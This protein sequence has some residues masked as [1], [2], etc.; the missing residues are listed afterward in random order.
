MSLI[1]KMLADLEARA[2]QT[3][4]MEDAPGPVHEGLRAA[5]P[6]GRARP[7]WRSGLWAG[8]LAVVLS[9]AVASVLLRGMPDRKDAAVASRTAVATTAAATVTGQPAVA[10]VSPQHHRPAGVD[11]APAGRSPTPASS[12][13]AAAARSSSAAPVVTP[14]PVVAVLPDVS[15]AS[16]PRH[17][18]AE[19][20]GRHAGRALSAA[21][22]TPAEDR[23]QPVRQ[24]LSA[25][26]A[27]R[28]MPAP[29]PLPR[30]AARSPAPDAR[31]AVS[32]AEPLAI[33]RSDGNDAAAV[34]RN[35]FSRALE[36]IQQARLSEAEEALRSALQYDPA[37][38]KARVTLAKVLIKQGRW[39]EAR[40]LL[41]DG[42]VDDA[43]NIELV[44]LLARTYVEQNDLAG[45]AA[46]V[47]RHVQAS[48]RDPELA[49]LM[50][51]IYQQLGRFDEAATAYQRAL[52]FR[53]GEGRLWLGMG[54]ALESERKWE[55]ARLAYERALATVTLPPELAAF[56][57][58]RLQFAQ[59]R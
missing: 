56:T 20:Q 46:L 3:G 45:A 4:N 41:A 19:E 52:V 34:A 7:W 36:W 27:S 13:R 50:G 16:P 18:R 1:N 17:R 44:K 38:V 30:P 59:R 22:G 8:A 40:N 55:E 32:S 31:P 25:A 11:P 23:R 49:G 47:D 2:A 57:R 51:H 54:L 10:P 29:P 9:A 37:L 53:P 43:N 35:H 14:A 21:P 42:L 12:G 39:V 28:Q 5:L 48:R 6:E 15:P 24:R 26:A 33:R 58:K